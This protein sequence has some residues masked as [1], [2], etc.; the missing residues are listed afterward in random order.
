MRSMKMKNK[1]LL[2][3]EFINEGFLSKTLNRAKTGDIRKES[4]KKV[5]ILPGVD[6]VITD[7]ELDYVWFVKE[8]C[9][10]HYNHYADYRFTLDSKGYESSFK[11]PN[12]IMINF[13]DY[14]MLIMDSVTDEDEICREDYESI[15]DG[16]KRF[17]EDKDLIKC[18]GKWYFRLI[19][20]E[21]FLEKNDK[22]ENED[23]TLF[24][25]FHRKFAWKFLKE[26]FPIDIFEYNIIM[27][28]NYE[29]MSNFL[30]ITDFTNA[31][32]GV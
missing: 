5:N 4:G 12:N 10:G 15:I 28:I 27:E 2:F 9:N 8:I 13:P 11:L 18:E 16:I 24:N 19:P 1:V 23:D 32:F 31:Y 6:I 30:K 26:N 3:D 21:V 29:T 14:D 25:D 20:H 22:F 7:P 17:M